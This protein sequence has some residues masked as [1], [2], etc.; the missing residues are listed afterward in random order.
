MELFDILKA[1]FSDKKWQDVTKQEKA[2]NFFMINRI[3]SISLPLQANAFNNTKIDPV[4]VIDFWK[5]TLNTK[6]KTPPGWFFTSTN[7]KEKKKEYA[8]KEEVLDLIRSKFEIS[9][10]EIKELLRYY[11]KEFKSFCESIEEQ[12]AG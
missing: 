6:Y 1:F 7:K 11:P 5:F 4:S 3:M 9:N 2:K 10:R 8:P 12:I